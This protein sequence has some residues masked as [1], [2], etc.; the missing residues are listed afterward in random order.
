MI[1]DD[2][3]DFHSGLRL[4]WTAQSDETGRQIL[5]MRKSGPRTA[6]KNELFMQ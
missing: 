3:K 5:I 4:S 2:W 1:G 6:K